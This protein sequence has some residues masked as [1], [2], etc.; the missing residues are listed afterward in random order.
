MGYRISL[1]N[2]SNSL[3]NVHYYAH[4]GRGGGGGRE[5]NTNNTGFWWGLYTPK[6]IS[7]MNEVN[8]KW[9]NALGDS[10]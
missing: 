1:K 10:G 5:N 3:C 4:Y 7:N 2:A 6:P 9:L 8:M